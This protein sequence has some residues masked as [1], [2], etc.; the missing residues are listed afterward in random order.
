MKPKLQRKLSKPVRRS[1]EAK[2]SAKPSPR[3]Y[4]IKF[5]APFRPDGATQE[6]FLNTVLVFGFFTGRSK[7]FDMFDPLPEKLCFAAS[8]GNT[9]AAQIL[10]NWAVGACLMVAALVGRRPQIMREIARKQNLWPVVGSTKPR[11]ETE[12][13]EQ[14]TGLGLGEDIQQ[15]DL[16]FR[17]TTGVDV[18]FASRQ[19]AKAA[20]EC[21]NA[22]RILQRRLASRQK[23][24]RDSLRQGC[25]RCAEAP[26]WALKAKDLPDFSRDKEVLRQWAEVIRELIR[27]Q[28]PDFQLRPEWKNRVRSCEARGRG[29]KGEVQNAIL[30]NIVS[31][32]RTVAP[33]DANRTC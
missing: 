23:R 5:F 33:G 32:L 2:V 1:H 9:A 6:D 25:W 17:K 30:D 15:I 18:N 8:A 12:V 16:R 3:T 14:L 26:P 10:V 28:I 20:V 27:E 24:D 31:A 22:T 29:S 19:W 13:L 4:T 21:V 11:W 7:L